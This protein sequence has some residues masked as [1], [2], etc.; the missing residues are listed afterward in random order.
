[1]F[2]LLFVLSITP[3]FSQTNIK[4]YNLDK[5][6]ALNGSDAERFKIIDGKLLCLRFLS[7]IKL[8]WG[9]DGGTLFILAVTVFA[10]S[11]FLAIFHRNQ[12]KKLKFIK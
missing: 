9:K 10:I 2:I 8:T 7:N 1:M 12:Y 4:K 11:A 5:E 6:V 3:A